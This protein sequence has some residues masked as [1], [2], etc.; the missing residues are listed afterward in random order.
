MISSTIDANVPNTNKLIDHLC[1]YFENMPV[2][3][4]RISF[5]GS[6]PTS[7]LLT[8]FIYYAISFPLLL[9]SFLFKSI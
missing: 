3:H 7:F 5:E 8:S 1:M 2:S 6:D 9:H 4:T